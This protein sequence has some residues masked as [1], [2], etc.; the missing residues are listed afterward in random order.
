MCQ[1]MSRVKTTKNQKKEKY[2]GQQSKEMDCD[3]PHLAPN[4]K[5]QFVQWTKRPTG[6][7]VAAGSL[8]PRYNIYQKGTGGFHERT[9]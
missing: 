7:L 6:A 4:E 9:D 8:W 2:S 1:V 5:T 3:E